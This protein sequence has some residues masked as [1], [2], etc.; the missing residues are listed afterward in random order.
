MSGRD[1]DIAIL[2][3]G[4]AGG[5]T[6]LALAA[7][8]PDLR[9][10]VV[11]AGPVCGGNH[12]WSFFDGDVDEGDRWLVDPLVVARWDRHSVRFPAG[13]GER[14]RVLPIGYNSTTGTRMDSVLRETLPDGAVIT[15]SAVLEVGLYHARLADGRRIEAGAVIDARGARNWPG[16]VGGWQKF[17]G[18]MVRTGRH[19]ITAPI[20][21]DACVEQVDG[22]RFVYVLPFDEETLFVEDT[23]YSTDPHLD[24]DALAGRIADW[25]RARGLACQVLGEERGVLPVV[26]GGDGDAFLKAGHQPGVARLGARAG[27]FHPLTSYSLPCAVAMA[28]HVARAGSFLP[29]ALDGLCL[30]AA[31]GH[32]RDGAYFRLLARMMFGAGSSGRRWRV[33]DHFYRQGDGLIARFYAGQMSGFD[34]LRLLLG[35][36]PVPVGRAIACLLGAG[37]PLAALDLL[38]DPS[39]PASLDEGVSAPGVTAR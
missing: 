21:M 16:L 8:R 35:R 31:R 2:G 37:A 14:E 39:L 26:A 5:L 30:G 28:L 36:P 10:V 3:G 6:A 24:R 29:A 25:V 15:G 18:Q 20:I 23:Y 1:A 33:F 12:V 17:V 9:V 34:R 4:L 13:T 11:E 19:G 32:W 38:P 7:L 27:L 22:Y